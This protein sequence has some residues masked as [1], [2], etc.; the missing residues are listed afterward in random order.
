MV[1]PE[2]IEAEPFE[3]WIAENAN[4]PLALVAVVD[5]EVAGFAG[6]IALGARPGVLENALTAV[7]R[8]YRGR[9][10]ATALKQ[11]LIAW[12]AASGYREIVTWTQQGNAA[13][14]AVNEKVGY[15]LG[16]VSIT[17]RGPLLA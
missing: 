2:P 4:G 3:Q 8:E 12:A 14:Q 16:H 11:A 6:L 5:G 15:R 1:L 9:E 7:R 13:M 17:L 10:I